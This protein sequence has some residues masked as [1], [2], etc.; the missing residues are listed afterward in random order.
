MAGKTAGSKKDDDDPLKVF[1]KMSNLR[2]MVFVHVQYDNSFRKIFPHVPNVTSLSIRQSDIE[3]LPE[4]IEMMR[5]LVNLQLTNTLVESLPN[6]VGNLRNLV[7][8]DVSFNPRLVSLP[9]SI[10]ELK[11]L[12]K[13]NV[14]KCPAL[15][16]LPVTLVGCTALTLIN[17][18]K[19]DTKIVPDCVVA[20]PSLTDIIH[21]YK[22]V[23]SKLREMQSL[24]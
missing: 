13:L 9:D 8:L 4:N 22:N 1:E 21:K 10:G 3:V 23:L 2:E 12:S 6:T 16:T 5:S 20:M 11:R 19:N 7:V 15:V 24:T 18:N 14:E 17:C